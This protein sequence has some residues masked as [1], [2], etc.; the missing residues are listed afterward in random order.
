[1]NEFSQTTSVDVASGDD[2][3]CVRV[4]P[5][6]EVQESDDEVTW[7]PAVELGAG[8]FSLS[9]PPKRHLRLQRVSPSLSQEP[10]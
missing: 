10:T 8:L 2:F 1:M 3:T 9:K 5:G 7:T 6:C 4:Q